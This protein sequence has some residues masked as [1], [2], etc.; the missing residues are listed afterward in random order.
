MGML[1]WVWASD[2][3][4][5]CQENPLCLGSCSYELLLKA[6]NPA[7]RLQAQVL[8]GKAWVLGGFQEGTVNLLLEALR[9]APPSEAALR[10]EV[11]YWLAQAYQRIAPDSAQYY[12]KLIYEDATTPP[13]WKAKAALALSSLLS[14]RNPTRA[15]AYASDALVS[16]KQAGD[17]ELQALALNQLAFLAAEIRQYPTAL[18]YAEEALHLAR[19]IPKPRLRSAILTN[20]AS[21]YDDMGRSSDA[22]KLYQEAL[23]IAPDTLSRTHV[24]LNLATHYYNEKKTTETERLLNQVALIL[25]KLP[26]SLRQHYYRLRFYIAMER[27]ALTEA[28]KYFEFVLSEADKALQEAEVNRTAQLEQLSGLRQRESR[29]RQLELSRRQERIFYG[30]MGVLALVGLGGV[31]YA[32]R[33]ARRRAQ[34]EAAFRQEIEKLNR[35]LQHQS[36]ELERQ[37][38]ELIR[39]SNALFEALEDL[40]DSINAA[41]RL[42]KALMPPLSQILPGTAFHYQPMQQIGGDFYIAT[43]DVFSGRYLIAVGD[44][45]GHGVP[46]AILASVFGATI[47]NFF[48]Q[49]PRQSAQALLMRVHAFASRLLVSQEADKSPLREGCDAAIVIFDIPQQKVE[50]GLAGRPLWIWEPQA[51]LQE[52]EGGR[53]GLD[54]FTPSDYEFPAYTLSLSPQSVFYLFTDGLTDV[55]NPQGRRWGIRRLRE[56]ISELARQGLSP[57]DQVEAILRTIQ[58]WRGEAQANDDMTL[59]IVPTQGILT[60]VGTQ[61][62]HSA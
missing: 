52:L 18:R 41:E 59:L 50:V 24:L 3:C 28:A 12:Y 31:G 26:F 14:G 36:E 43:R 37:N 49:N 39:V 61:T 17:A 38:Q 1:S 57:A 2:P 20:L 42:Q 53:R 11:R 8:L 32:Y 30:L 15:Q 6:E 62:S 47:Q 4:A 54:S 51:G 35:S 58:T 10:A 9:E 25:S 23:Q 60:R 45:T 5:H 21:I 46:G 29:L 33:T 44:A 16:A 40:R 13:Y 22:L 27:K 48:L 19:S 55:L 56:L 34:E 7:E